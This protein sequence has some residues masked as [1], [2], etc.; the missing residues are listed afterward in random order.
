[1]AMAPAIL[2]RDRGM[3][4]EKELWPVVAKVMHIATK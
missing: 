2:T 1:M 3:S 4:Q